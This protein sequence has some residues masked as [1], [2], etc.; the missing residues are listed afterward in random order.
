MTAAPGRRAESEF[1]RVR[2]SRD[3]GE[4]ETAMGGD[5]AYCAYALAQL[6]PARFGRARFWL[7]QC[8]D[9]ASGIVVQARGNGRTML[10]IGNPTAVGAA[11]ALHPGPP[12]SYLAT[13]APEHLPALEKTHEATDRLIMHR[14][15]TTADSF[16]PAPDAPA[17]PDVLPLRRL[18]DVDVPALNQL[19]R[20]GGAP[21]HYTASDLQRLPYWGAFDGRRLAA[22]AGTHVVSPGRG[23]GVVGNV[24][25]HPSYRS[26]GLGTRVTGAV[27]ATL[28]AQG[29]GL[30]VLTVDPTNTRAVRAYRRLGYERGADVVEARLVRRP[31]EG[32][33]SWWRRLRAR[34]RAGIRAAASGGHAEE[35]VERRR[36]HPHDGD[37]GGA[38]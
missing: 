23:V 4:L 18:S 2:E 6:D 27:T 28:L 11:L 15:Q 14:M 37:E 33:R 25:T 13:A 7:A 21:A 1:V 34:R 36:S 22:V 3:P 5:R 9:G 31:V 26:R 24:M 19:Y 12:A 8:A 35:W 20:A 32:V 30:I 16:R 10:L 38:R 29:L 17:D